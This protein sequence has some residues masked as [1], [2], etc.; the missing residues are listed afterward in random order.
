V[1]TGWGIE[2]TISAFFDAPLRCSDSF[3]RDTWRWTISS[4]LLGFLF[5]VFHPFYMFLQKDA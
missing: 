1:I 5:I 3:Q 2:T 4:M